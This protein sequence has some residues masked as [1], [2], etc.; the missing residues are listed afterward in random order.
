MYEARKTYLIL[1]S[2]RICIAL[3]S[4]GV[5]LFIIRSSIPLSFQ[6]K[7]SQGLNSIHRSQKKKRKKHCD[8]TKPYLLN[9][10]KDDSS[11]KRERKCAK[12][13]ATRAGIEVVV[14][15]TRASIMGTMWQ[16]WACVG[17]GGSERWAEVQACTHWRSRFYRAY[18]TH[19]KIYT[20]A[21]M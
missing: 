6:L 8:T 18:Y 20:Y 3:K 16:R 17:V 21:R 9:R 5:F 7:I 15:I 4:V 11:G 2:L 14:P 13:D 19:R 10:E 1:T 12:N